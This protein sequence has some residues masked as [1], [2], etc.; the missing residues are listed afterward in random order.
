MNPNLSDV[1]EKKNPIFFITNNNC[2]YLNMCLIYYFHLSSMSFQAMIL[3]KRLMSSLRS[4]SNLHTT[5]EPI[6]H[7]L[8]DKLDLETPC[9][10]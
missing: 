9:L 6:L 4:L 10:K 3:D 8:F 2:K 1:Q 7:F 5:V